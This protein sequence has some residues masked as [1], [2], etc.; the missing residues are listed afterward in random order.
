MVKEANM[1]E[2]LIY[3]N[4]LIG[5][6]AFAVVMMLGMFSLIPSKTYEQLT[7]SILGL[8]FAPPVIVA[9]IATAT[10]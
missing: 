9:L 6:I 2:V 8:T 5:I 4:L 1:A 7:L 3:W 10:A